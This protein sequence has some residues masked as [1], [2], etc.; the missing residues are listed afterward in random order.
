MKLYAIRDRLLDYYLRPFAAE[1][2]KQVLASLAETINNVENRAPIAQTPS[3]FE[4]WRLAEIDENTGQVQGDREFLADCASLVRA[5]LRET[6]I[7]G[8]AAPAAAGGSQPAAAGAAG[9][10][11]K[12]NAGALPGAAHPEGQQGAEA[13]KGHQGGPNGRH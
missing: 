5:D 7:R 12:A 1:G 13:A 10:A 3:H 11:A 4:L 8:G 2:D 6:R 9:E